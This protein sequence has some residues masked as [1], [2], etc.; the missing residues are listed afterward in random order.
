MRELPYYSAFA[1]SRSR[2]FWILPV[3]VLG[4]GP[5]TICFGTLNPANRGAAPGDDLLGRDRCDAWLQADE[6]A[7][8][9]APFLVGP[10]H[11]RGFEDGGMA[12]QDVFH[13]ECGDV[14]PARDDDV[15][16]AVL[17]LHVTVGVNHRQVSGVVPA[18]AKRF[19]RGPGVLQVTLHR[20]VAAEEDL[21]HRLRVAR[22]R[23]QRLRV[24]H[25]H[26]LL[27]RVR[28]ALAP[29]QLRALGD[30]KTHPTPAAWHTRWPDRIPRS[31]HTRG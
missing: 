21:A 24:G 14:F 6:R 29:V 30:G 10:G 3:E 9:L 25:H 2:F 5:N 11:D 22:D 13:F 27:E 19:F 26:R 20:D 4:S 15:L 7:G 1:C 17:D 28:D 31:G 16:G 23:L 12:V 18:A 8:R